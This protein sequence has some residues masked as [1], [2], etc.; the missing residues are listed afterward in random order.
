MALE[1]ALII[2]LSNKKHHERGRHST[3]VAFT[4]K[5]LPAPEFFFRKN[6][7][8]ADLIDSKDSAR[9][10]N[11]LIEPIEYRREHYCKKDPHLTEYCKIQNFIT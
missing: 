3:A 11:K 1:Q 8:I 6:Y 4:L 7:D 10:I 5:A 2:L 9:K